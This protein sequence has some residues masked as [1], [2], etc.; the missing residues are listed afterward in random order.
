MSAM[1]PE[2]DGW[3]AP[4]PRARSPRAQVLTL[5]FP[6]HVRMVESV[7]AFV[8]EVAESAGF[9]PLT[10]QDIALAVHEAVI[11]AIVHGNHEDESRRVR[12]EIASNSA[13]V[14]IRVQDQGRA[15]DAAC[16]ADPRAAQNL[17]KP[18]GRGILFMRALMDEVRFG[19]GAGGGTQ[20]SMLKRR[21]PAAA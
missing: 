12:L 17:C 4:A 2:H 16:V 21:M 19:T 14:E 15:F 3:A 8:G 20:V 1:T 6:S 5:E 9:D 18:C 11:N 7:D 13:G 10:A